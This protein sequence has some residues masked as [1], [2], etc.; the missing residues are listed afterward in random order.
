MKAV[1]SQRPG[2]SGRTC[3][4]MQDSLI[5]GSVGTGGRKLSSRIHLSI[6]E[7]GWPALKTRCLTYKFRFFTK[8][9]N[10]GLWGLDLNLP[11]LICFCFGVCFVL[12]CFLTSG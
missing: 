1:L 8:S 7:D 11:W 12:F 6:E 10:V 2:K 4:P 5:L 9:E 3:L